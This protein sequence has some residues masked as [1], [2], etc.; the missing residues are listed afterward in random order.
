MPTVLIVD[1]EAAIGIGL[2]TLL[3]SEGVDVR[4]AG[5]YSEAEA[6]LSSAPVTVLITDV[7]LP[8][9]G[10]ASG[11]DLLRTV[12]ERGLA[13]GTIVMTGYGAPSVLQEAF[14]LGADFYFEKPVEL[15]LLA[16][17]LTELGVPCNF[18]PRG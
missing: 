3:D 7:R 1:D 9:A 11:L 5:S 15:D 16:E 12:K 2:K 18:T 8:G 14:D 4:T 6:L 17:A 10:D 13:T